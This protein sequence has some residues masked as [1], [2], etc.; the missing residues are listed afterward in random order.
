MPLSADS[1]VPHLSRGLLRDRPQGNRALVGHDFEVRK[2]SHVA[3]RLG[4][5]DVHK[6]QSDPRILALRSRLKNEIHPLFGRIQSLRFRAEEID[7][8]VKSCTLELEPRKND[9]PGLFPRGAL[10]LCRRCGTWLE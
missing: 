3:Q 8:F 5:R 4:K 7:A 9:R 6:T 1:S 2:L 10:D